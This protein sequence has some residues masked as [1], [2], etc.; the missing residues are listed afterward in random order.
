V[1][2][3]VHKI[4][5]CAGLEE[6]TSL[7]EKEAIDSGENERHMRAAETAF[8]MCKLSAVVGWRIW[9]NCTALRKNPRIFIIRKTVIEYVILATIYLNR[10]RTTYQQ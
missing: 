9:I 4:P 5:G 3:R 7:S 2:Y 8:E 1:W 6:A 10:C